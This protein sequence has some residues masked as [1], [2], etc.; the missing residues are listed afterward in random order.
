M[1]AHRYRE[2]SHSG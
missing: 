1:T 2:I